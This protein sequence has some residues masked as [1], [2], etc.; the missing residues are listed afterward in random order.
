MTAWAGSSRKQR[1]PPDWTARREHVLQ[2]DHYRCVQCGQPA[3]D[4]DHIIPGDHHELGNLQ[5]L[6]VP[7]HKHKSASEG[8]DARWNRRPPEPHPGLH[9]PHPPNPR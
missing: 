8:N 4:V 2:R 5:S 7:C 6:C 1:L 3:I 9:P